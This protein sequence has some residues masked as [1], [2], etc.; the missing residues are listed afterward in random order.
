MHWW[1][2]LRN[3]ISGPAA[4]V[5]ASS[6]ETERTDAVRYVRGATW[7]DVFHLLGLLERHGAEYVLVGGYALGFNGLV[8]QTGDVDVLVTN[9]PEN[10]RRWIAAL[11]ELPDGAASELMS[12]SED[13]FI[14]SDDGYASDGEPGVIRIADE[15]LVDVM[16]KACGL[17]FEE[18]RPHVR[19]VPHGDAFV[20][21]LDL[22]GLRLTKQG[23]RA[24]DREDLR[25]VEAAMRALKGG[26]ADH[27]ENMARRQF[28]HEPPPVPGRIEFKPMADED[29]ARREA[30]A[31]Q[32]AERAVRDGASFD[33][34][35]DALAVYCDVDLLRELLEMPGSLADL[36]EVLSQRG[37]QL[38][39]RTPG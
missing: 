11:S 28:S 16:P 12:E 32:V 36:H 34:D 33:P 21:V 31:R 24:K 23:D 13:P 15:F 9:T 6:T 37:I 18:L 29:A 35:C 7:E 3:W 27:V 38:P 20:N 8:R 26:V 30:L 10:N 14:T 22:Q 2:A 17:T 1:R 19:R 4:D 25:H 39:R 5:S